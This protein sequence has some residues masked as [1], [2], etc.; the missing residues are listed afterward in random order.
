MWALSNACA[1]PSS[2]A[3]SAE[4]REEAGSNAAP[5]AVSTAAVVEA[6][7][8]GEEEWLTEG[9]GWL[10]KKVRSGSTIGS[11]SPGAMHGAIVA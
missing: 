7:P 1:V 3:A 10:G 2:A 11:D 5:P 9:H 4:F 8:G 6:G